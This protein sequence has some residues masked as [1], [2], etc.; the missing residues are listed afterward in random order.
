MDP[1][2]LLRH[3]TVHAAL[4]RAWHDSEPGIAGGHE[5]GGFVVQEPTGDL[6][7]ERWPRGERDSI[8]VPPHPSCTFNGMDIIASFHTH[9][10][11]GPDYLQEPG[12]T[13]RRAI[14]DDP[15]LMGAF[16]LG[17][18]V[19]AQANIYFIAPAGQVRILESAH[20]LMSED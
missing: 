7:V 8:L 19:I 12:D 9:P 10:N 1:A 13:D 2:S 11:T 14:R 16:Y 5:E 6:R 17:E 20:G 15:D 18:V 4:K 3:P